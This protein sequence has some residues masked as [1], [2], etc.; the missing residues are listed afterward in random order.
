M[1]MRQ[2]QKL[3]L[4]EEISVLKWIRSNTLDSFPQLSSGAVT[5][6]IPGQLLLKG[7]KRLLLSNLIQVS[8]RNFTCHCYCI[9]PI[10]RRF[11]TETEQSLSFN[12]H[13]K[14]S[15]KSS[16]EGRRLQVTQ[17]RL[18]CSVPLHSSQKG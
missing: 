5:W 17:A 9:V 12:S 8:L 11:I 16:R 7:G 6:S 14:C 1:R 4:K 18:M 3:G 2:N 15:G 10:T 13:S